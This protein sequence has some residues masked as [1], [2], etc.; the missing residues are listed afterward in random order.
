MTTSIHTSREFGTYVVTETDKGISEI[1]FPTKLTKIQTTKEA[2]S[3]KPIDFNSPKEYILDIQG[4][5]FQKEVWR[6]LQKIRPGETKTYKEVAE[7]IGRP[8][9]VRAVGTAIGQNNIA[10]LI[11][12]HRVIRADGKLGGFRWGEKLKM[13]LLQ[14]EGVQ[15]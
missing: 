3:R 11:P 12:C 5:P 7:M 1:Q 2:L 8:K 13:K 10:I 14:S 4:T 6:A 15:V 9:A